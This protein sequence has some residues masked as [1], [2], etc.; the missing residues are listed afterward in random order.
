MNDETL[1]SIARLKA[2]KQWSAD[3]QL[4]NDFNNEFERYL[5]YLEEDQGVKI[6][7]LS[8]TCEK[9]L[10]VPGQEVK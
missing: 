5:T 3:A 6:K 10:V 2:E 4:R 7:M 1:P 9:M 8:G